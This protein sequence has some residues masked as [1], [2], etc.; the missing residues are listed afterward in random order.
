MRSGQMPNWATTR[1]I[2]SPKPRCDPVE[3]TPNLGP[4]VVTVYCEAIDIL[5]ESQNV[6]A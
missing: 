4:E 3:Q 1:L 6:V 2:Y 5:T